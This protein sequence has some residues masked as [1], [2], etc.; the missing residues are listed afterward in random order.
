MRT[1]IF[2]LLFVMNIGAT[3]R[4]PILKGP[5]LGQKSPEMVPEI[6]AP[7]LLNNTE[8]GAFCTVFSP[9]GT[10]F[11]FG[12]YK[13]S[14][15]ACDLYRMK[16]KSGLWLKPEKL[17]FNSNSYENDVC[18]SADGS[19]LVFRSWRALPNGKK[20]KNHSYLWFVKRNGKGWSD[21]KPLLC[22]GD[23][24]RTGYPSLS[25]DNTLYFAHRQDGRLG[26]YRSRLQKGHYN[27]PEFVYEAFNQDFILGDLFVAPDERYIIFSGR[28]PE[29]GKEF[30]RLDLYVTFREMEN[31]WSK[32]LKMGHN[33]NTK[34]GGENCPAVSPDGKYF[35]FN[36]YNPDKKRGNMYWVSAAVITNIKK[37][38]TGTQME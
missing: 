3:D 30:T 6:F 34:Q 36:R 37:K 25:R 33:I 7:G 32:P 14:G 8:M 11:Y 20:P 31:R 18:I 29:K 26:I 10:E 12:Y 22:G 13:R 4:W 19:T 23:P 16:Q 27:K 1:L 9:D 15:D 35:F 17:P 2:L 21:A 28:P 5:Y 24:V 38:A